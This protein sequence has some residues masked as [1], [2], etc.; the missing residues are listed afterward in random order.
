MVSKRINNNR[1]LTTES[2]LRN[3]ALHML[4]QNPHGSFI[5]DSSK[6]V[7]TLDT[8]E[9]EAALVQANFD[10]LMLHFRYATVGKKDINNVHGWQAGN[11]QFLHN[12][13]INEYNYSPPSQNYGYQTQVQTYEQEHS[14]S[15]LLFDDLRLE[16]AKK[17]DKHDKDVI[18]AIKQIINNVTFWGRAILVD[19][20]KDIAYLF[21]DWY[22]YMCD[23]SYIIFSSADI[24][25]E[26]EYY[27]KS[28]GVRFEYSEKPLKEMTF[29][30]IATIR[31][32]SKP[33]YRF[34]FRGDLKDYG[35][36][37]EDENYSRSYNF[38]QYKTPKKEPT[39]I[40]QEE[41]KYQLTEDAMFERQEDLLDVLEGVPDYQDMN[42]YEMDTYTKETGNNNDNGICYKNNCFRI[43]EE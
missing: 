3:V 35:Y 32:F 37:D 38:E 36:V 7:R 24:N 11:Y 17:G 9:A 5:Q 12:G 20:V 33:N 16:I 4:R 27:L 13:G 15:K 40:E 1:N 43:Y 39:E 22:V 28:H 6:S 14:D 23:D 25:V 8:K 2:K 29:D 42:P 41:A 18:E 31:N 19:T 26:Q 30:G 34:R 10:N 21:G